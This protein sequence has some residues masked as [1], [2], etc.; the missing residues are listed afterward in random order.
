MKKLTNHTAGP[1]GVNLKNGTTRWIEPGETVEIDAGDIVGDVPDLGKAGK[2]EPD[3]AALIDAVQAEN[4]ALK[5]EVADLKAQIAKFDA[6]G[7]GKPGG[8]KAGS[9]TQN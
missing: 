8:S 7:D 1:K 5:K 9:K 2:A 6:D 3:D 4:A